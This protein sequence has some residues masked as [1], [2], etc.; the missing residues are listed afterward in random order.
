MKILRVVGARPQ[1]M[2]VPVL[3]KAL[4]ERGHEHI[5]LHTGQHYDENM[6]SNFFR[7][8]G[9]PE[10]DINLEISNLSHAAMTGRMMEG[11][12]KCII[13][14]TPDAVLVDGDTNSTM[15]AALAAAKLH[16]PIIHIEAG[17]RDFDKRRPEEINRIVTD[18]IADLN[19]APIPRAI[20]NLRT[21]GLSESAILS[22]DLL[23]DC[24]S[25]YHPLRSDRVYLE[26]GLKEKQFHIATL[27]RPENTNPS[28]RQRFFDIVD[29]LSAT[30]KKV[31][32]PI[33]PRSKPMFERYK[34][35][36]K[37]LGNIIL[38][39]PTTYLEMLGLLEHADCVFTDSGG[40]P[41]EAIWSGCKC[42]MLFRKDTWHD[43]L[44]HGWATI[45]KTDR[46]SIE[47]AF[48]LAVTPD[49][50]SAQQFFG[51]GMAAEKIAQ[52]L[53]QIKV[54]W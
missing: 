17:L 49:A 5:L 16:V 4:L 7:E 19:C 25:H 43:M 42:V 2:Q 1:F 13:K 10:P 41:R 48:E 36:R 8:L 51:G 53:D 3:R 47:K 52:H 46:S 33:H 24:Y 15:A 9:I 54:S 26:L 37:T 34:E 38:I 35:A 21:E 29:T 45:G 14:H 20:D 18:H 11:I 40:L 39:P 22:G 23:L 6:S 27:H 32:L 44:E 31:I 12:E 50:L 28:E 30:D